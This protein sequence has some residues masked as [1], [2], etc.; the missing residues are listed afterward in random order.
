MTAKMLCLL[1]TS[2]VF[3]AYY[4]LLPSCNTNRSYGADRILFPFLMTSAQIL[5]TELVLG[6]SGL[7]YPLLLAVVNGAVSLLV[8]VYSGKR[9]GEFRLPGQIWADPGGTGRV[10]GRTDIFTKTLLA[11]VIL[12]Y[13]WV[14]TAAYFLPLRGIDDLFYHLPPIFNYIQTHEISLLPLDIRQHF[15]FPQNAELLFMWP[16]CF[17]PDITMLDAVNVLFVLVSIVVV[18][19]ML[20]SAQIRE[21][22][23]QFISLLYAM[24][25][26]V[27]MQAG[28]NYIDVPVALFLLLG[29]YYTVRYSQEPQALYACCAAAAIGIASGMKYSAFFLALPLQAIMLWKML[30]GHKRHLR[31]YLPLVIMLCCWWY[32]RNFA[33]MGNPFYPMNI[34]APGMG[35]M[36]GG[37]QSL[38][39]NILLNIRSWFLQF[40]VEDIGL[41]SYDGGFGL[42][43]WGL[44]FPSWLILC[45][46]ELFGKQRLSIERLLP[47]IYLPIGF[48][49][50]LAV[51]SK[52]LLYDGR[53]ALFV[54]AIGLFSIG[55]VMMMVHDRVYIA[56][57]K[58]ACVVFSLFTLGLMSRSTMPSYR[59]DQP[60]ADIRNGQQPS[61]YRYVA[62]ANPVYPLLSDFWEPL[63]L[64]TRDNKPGLNCYIA[65][66]P[67][68]VAL[69]PLYGSRLQNR[70]INLYKDKGIRAEAL[71]YL[72]YPDRYSFGKLV[73]RQISYY[74]YKIAL[75]D[76]LPLDEY[77]V[78]TTNELGSLLIDKKFCMN[79]VKLDRLRNF[80]RQ[81]W[82]DAVEAARSLQPFLV[83]GLPLVTAHP[84]AYGLRVTAE[85]ATMDDIILVQSGYER[86]V[87]EKRRLR[88]FYS[89]E[90]PVAG[91][92]AIK[93][94]T[95][96]YQDQSVGLYLN[97]DYGNGKI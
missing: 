38:S 80:Y 27:I 53:L 13:A 60:F 15:A 33:V 8:I 1:L 89:L 65:S 64:L 90:R 49:M 59:L 92:T 18:H 23:A 17:S 62:A 48:L 74:G 12:T 3:L 30:S 43:F 81:R 61:E 88:R 22:H 6:V 58:I 40:P 19:A 29:I 94:T 26:V 95:I 25:P 84:L 44:G 79:P 91:Y 73:K 28:S 68:L 45:S 55:A 67:G 21:N 31:L 96:T 57:I 20:R 56:T 72:A 36:A 16:L 47:C 93:I 77:L 82:P 51:T 34:S 54:I 32:I 71:L 97:G 78:V 14:L 37:N 42:V 50:L 75:D 11:I 87:T 41:G 7:L 69:A 9:G 52:E 4:Q 24:S 5:V 86:L 70:V 2:F 39:A 83:K 76:V 63:D 85:A 10:A 35:F 46:Y 66:H